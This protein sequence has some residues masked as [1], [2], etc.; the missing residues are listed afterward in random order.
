MTGKKGQKV[1][2]RSAGDEP[3]VRLVWDYDPKA[4][5]ICSDESFRIL[6]NVKGENYPGD[7]FPIGF[8]REYVFQF[9]AK[10]FEDLK[11]T[12]KHSSAWKGLKQWTERGE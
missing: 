1:I 2:V 7:C 3:L 10:A 4:V 12:Y 5:Y 6:S 8:P 11:K 9:D